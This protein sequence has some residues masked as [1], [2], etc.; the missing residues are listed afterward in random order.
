MYGVM[1]PQHLHRLR[2][3]NDSELYTSTSYTVEFVKPTTELKHINSKDNSKDMYYDDYKTKPLNND[4]FKIATEYRENHEQQYEGQP[5][6]DKEDDLKAAIEVLDNKEQNNERSD[7]NLNLET[8]RK[9]IDVDKILESMTTDEMLLFKQALSK[10]PQIPF[11]LLMDEYRWRYFEG[12][13]SIYFF[14][15][16]RKKLHL[17]LKTKLRFW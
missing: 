13:F 5:I 1:T 14:M 7:H 4:Q 9:D 8:L 12:T 11:S 15:S 10:L 3:I 17:S 16:P 6:Y 2:L